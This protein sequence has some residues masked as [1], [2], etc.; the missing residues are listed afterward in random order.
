MNETIKSLIGRKSTRTFLNKKVP[1]ELKQLILKCATEA[2]TAGN[3]QLYT[4]IDIT[5]QEIKNKLSV[6]CDNQP[7]IAKASIVLIFCADCKKWYDAYLS[8]GLTARKPEEGDLLLAIEDAMISAQNA[9]VAAESLG[10]G[11]C[12]IGDILENREYHKQLLSI[13]D[14]VLPIGMLVIGYPSESAIKRPKP[15]RADIKYI[16]HENAHKALSDEELKTM[17][18]H[19]KRQ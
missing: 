2:P 1:D 15:Q 9:V 17:L 6:S 12:Y 19:K 3:Q 5:D 7:F 11:S 14:Y 16:V 18:S 13:P 8:A 4:I 10:L